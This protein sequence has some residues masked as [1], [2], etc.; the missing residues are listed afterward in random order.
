MAWQDALRNLEGSLRNQRENTVRK[1]LEKIVARY[2]VGFKFDP[3]H[4][5]SPTRLNSAAAIS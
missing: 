1:S 5:L 3:I 2:S 4:T